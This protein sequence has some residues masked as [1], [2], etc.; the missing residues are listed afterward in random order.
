MSPALAAAL[1]WAEALDH[2]DFDRLPELL[3]PD[4]VYH[5]PGNDLIGPEAIITSYRQSSLWAHATF[6]SIRW[7]SSCEPEGD[8]AALITFLD[9]TDHRGQHHEYRCRQRVRVGSDGLIDEITHLPIAEE[10][11]RLADFFERVG[12]VR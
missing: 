5:N 1:R 6:D 9:I 3:A 10:E 2:D 7:D 11:G 4:C 8:D 12:V